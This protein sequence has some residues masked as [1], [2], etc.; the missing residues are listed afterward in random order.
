MRDHELKLKELKDKI[1][2]A[3]LQNQNKNKANPSSSQIGKVLR[4]AV[5]IVAAMAVGL[6]LGLL[7]DNYLETKPIFT[8]IFFLLGSCAGFLNIF[9]VAKSL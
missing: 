3:K 2:N 4:L 7:L 9:R 6:G 1:E 8:I 5:E